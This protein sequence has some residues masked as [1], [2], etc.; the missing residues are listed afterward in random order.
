MNEWKWSLSKLSGIQK[1]NLKVFSCFS[2]G[3]GSTMG[4]KLAG[5]DVIGNVEIDPRMMR[6]YKENH[7]PKFPFE[8]SV[9]EFKV[10]PDSQLPDELFNLDILDGSPPCSTFSVSGVR[11]KK[12]GGSFAFKEGQAKQNL[13]DLFFDFIDIV[14][15]LKPKVVIAENVKGLVTGKARGYVNE[16]IKKFEAVGYSVQLF[17]LNA[18]TMGV[19]QRRERV[20]FICHRKDLLFSKLSLNFS[21]APILYKEIEDNDG[22]PLNQET[23]TYNRWLRRRPQDRN[24]GDITFRE[25]GKD[26]NFNS[27][28]LHRNR[29]VPTIA[30]GSHLIKYD[31]P[32]SISDGEI[33]KAQTFPYDYNFLDQNVQYVCGMSVPPIMMKKIAEQ[34]YLQWFK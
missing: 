29:I 15:K 18:A 21:E 1:N 3:G 33:I 25:V 32:E 12:W 27:V 7:N 11:E 31:K 22:K 2:C 8:M 24:L 6:L 17:L 34:I 13:D 20:F 26:L 30:S 10:I 5:F 16:I 19:P 4:Y 9:Q 14:E 23:E 28:L